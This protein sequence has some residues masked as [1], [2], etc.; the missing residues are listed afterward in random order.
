MF[1]LLICLIKQI[2]RK[3]LEVESFSFMAFSTV[4]QFQLAVEVAKASQGKRKMDADG[5][6]IA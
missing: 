2:P 4:E 6:S 5:P 1:S 3:G